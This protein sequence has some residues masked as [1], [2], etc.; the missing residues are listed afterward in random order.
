M[1]LNVNIPT[2]SRIVNS[3]LDIWQEAT[4]NLQ[5]DNHMDMMSRGLSIQQ[6]LELMG[7]GKMEDTKHG[8]VAYCKKRRLYMVEDF[9]SIDQI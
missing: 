7:E 6:L 2:T 3:I 5:F 1:L 8:I 4:R 9:L